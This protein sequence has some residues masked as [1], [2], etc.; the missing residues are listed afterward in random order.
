M[1]PKP[2][3]LNVGNESNTSILSNGSDLSSPSNGSNSNSDSNG[4]NST[5]DSLYNNASHT[6]LENFIEIREKLFI[7][8]RKIMEEHIEGVAFLKTIRKL[9]RLE[10]KY[11]DKY[12]NESNLIKKEIIIFYKSYAD[13]FEKSMLEDTNIALE[14]KDIKRSI[15]KLFYDGT[16][17]ERNLLHTNKFI[18]ELLKIKHKKIEKMI[19]DETNVELFV[20]LYCRILF[21]EADKSLLE[22][23][24]ENMVKHVTSLNRTSRIKS[25]RNKQ[26]KL[27]N[28]ETYIQSLN[29]TSRIKSNRNKQ[30]EL[31]RKAKSVSGKLELT[32]ENKQRLSN[33]KSKSMKSH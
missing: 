20:W 22:N 27:E 6:T 7:D 10:S 3:P 4:T 19:E 24:L 21:L 12:P 28:M 13:I 33:R 32:E 8:M 30:L 14:I 5:N 26:N 29:R 2:R 25:N 18:I 15:R 9:K 1:P 23:K 17:E 31:S 11:L 16:L